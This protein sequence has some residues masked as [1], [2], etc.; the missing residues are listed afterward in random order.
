M[1]KVDPPC[2]DE[3]WN[4]TRADWHRLA[5]CPQQYLKCMQRNVL[6]TDINE[7]S[8]ILKW[9]ELYHIRPLFWGYI[10]LHSPYIG[11]IYGRY[12]QFGFLEWP[13]KIYSVYI[14]I[15]QLGVPWSLFEMIRASHPP[16][17]YHARSGHG[18][19]MVCFAERRVTYVTCTATAWQRRHGSHAKSNWSQ[20][21][22]GLGWLVECPK[23]SVVSRGLPIPT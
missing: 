3:T 22:I 8:R 7:N 20:A 2:S 18:L 13:L 10:P 21:P 5:T 14:S 19:G 12:L 23:I 1:M 17:V 11:L 15:L 16:C 9:R 6:H 4:G